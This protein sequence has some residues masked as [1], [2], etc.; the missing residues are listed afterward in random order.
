VHFC[1]GE[2]IHNYEDITDTLLCFSSFFLNIL[3][4][5]HE[6]AQDSII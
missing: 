6:T 1:S 4:N 5:E 2:K 3:L